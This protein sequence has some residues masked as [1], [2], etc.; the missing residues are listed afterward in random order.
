MISI[1]IIGASGFTGVRAAAPVRAPPRARR[2]RAP[3]ATRQAGTAV[4]D[5][6]PSLAAAY[7]ATS[8]SSR[9]SRDLLDDVDG[10]FLGLP[11]GASQALVPD[12]RRPREGGRR[13]RRRL[14][15]ARRRALR[16]VVRRAAHRSPT[17]S[18][19]FAYGLPEL[20]RTEHRAR[21]TRRRARVLPDGGHPRRS[22][23]WCG[24]GA[25]EPTGVIVDAASGVSG[26]GRPPKPTTTFCT[27]DEDFTAYGLLD[28]R[29]TPEMET[30]TGAI[31]AVHPAPR[32]DEPGHPGHLLRP[33]GPRAVTS[34]DDAARRA[35]PT[36]TP[37]SRSSSCPSGRRR[38]RRRSGSNCAHLT[39]RYDERTGTV[40]AIGAIDNLVKGT[41]GQAIQCMNLMAGLPETTG[42]PDRRD[43][44][45]TA[46]TAGP[47][48]SS[49]RRQRHPS[50]G[51][52]PPP[53]AAV[54]PALPGHGRRGEV[55]RQRHDR[56]RARSPSS[57]ATSC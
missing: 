28:H 10:V 35:R 49:R 34:T 26:A 1:G 3:P 22:R 23:R 21:P 56:P 36:P 4:A 38:P 53:G 30:H 44:P 57:R 16:A 15:A 18:T 51:R 50:R 45:V 29:H 6:Y 8:C 9:T 24:P 55:R 48:A 40:L 52:G 31:G 17:C 7:P 12:V 14:P 5:L 32:A 27:V 41:A 39:A 37:T 25:I 13:P 43:L 2:A 46:P 54:H 47:P 19:A 42:L 33:A 20:Y 11:H